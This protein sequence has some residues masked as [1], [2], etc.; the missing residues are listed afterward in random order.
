MS[1]KKI[2]IL[3]LLTLTTFIG[4]TQEKPKEK[5]LKDLN[6]TR[7]TGDYYIY[8][9][10]GTHQGKRYPAYGMYVVTTKG[11]V[12][13]DTPWDYNQVQP[14]LDSIS[15]KHHKKVVLAFAS[16][17][18]TDRTAG[19]DILQK[20]GIKT[21]S[22]KQ[23]YDLC[24]EYNEKQAEFYF[25]N[26]TTFRVGNHTFQTYYPGEG[27]SKDNIVIWCANKKVLYGGCLIKGI[28]GKEG[29]EYINV[30][31]AN[32]QQWS[33]SIENI[34]KKFPN[35]RYAIPG[36]DGGMSNKNLQH[37]IKLVHKYR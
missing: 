34:M 36:H 10:F 24:K 12:L 16:H 9:T 32:L 31:S 23:T 14:L 19:L 35:A 6:I 13:M 4:Y 2:F 30:P 18:H 17:Y 25:T 21:Y 28:G 29:K 20:Q 27:H 5:L 37:T 7:L 11:A 3:S 15:K 22:S 8:K 26:D 1:V 33:T